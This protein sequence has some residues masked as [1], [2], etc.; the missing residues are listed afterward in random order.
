[1]ST[2]LINSV[3]RRNNSLCFNCCNIGNTHN[4]ILHNKAM[5]TRYCDVTPSVR[6][7]QWCRRVLRLWDGLR[8][9]DTQ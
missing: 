4:T 2:K 9:E 7:A 5:R 8:N 6:I 3:T 1:M